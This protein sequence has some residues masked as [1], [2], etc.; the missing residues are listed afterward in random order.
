MTAGHSHSLYPEECLRSPDWSAIVS[1]QSLGH[2]ISATMIEN[3][4]F[5]MSL[6]DF[7]VLE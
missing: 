1:G 5:G 7:E 4:Q 6:T 2:F 3:T